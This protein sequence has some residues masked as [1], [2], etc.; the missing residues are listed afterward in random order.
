MMM[1][2]SQII[3]ERYHV[4]PG[5][6]YAD[7]S[8]CGLISRS[9]V[10]KMQTFMQQLYESGS[11]AANTFLSKDWPRIRMKVSNFV[12]A[13]KSEIALIPNF[14]TGL[15]AILP[16][17]KKHQNVLLFEDDYPSLTQPFVLNDF[18]IT[19]ISSTD[20]FHFDLEEIEAAIK[21]KGIKI[22][23][24]SEVQY[25]TGFSIDMEALG[26]ICKKEGVI[27]I[28]DGTQ[29]LGARPY[30]FKKSAADVY[31]SSNYKWM[32]GGYG[33]GLMAIK[34]AF[35]GAHPPKIGGFANFSEINGEWKYHESILNYEPGHM[36]M[37]GWLVVEDAVDFK[38]EIGTESIFR[39]NQRLLTMLID[40]L[41]NTDFLVGDAGI[42]HRC[43]IIC[44][45][46]SQQLIRSFRNKGVI[47]K[48]R[49]GKIRLGLHFH[50]T[51]KDVKNIINAIRSAV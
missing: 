13:D 6:T 1:I 9:G 41:K 3:Q 48:N 18:N 51:E 31:I 12:N 33:T 32:N 30:D 14:S 37:G 36:N 45:K 24:V 19:W 40:G 46:E 27:L 42:E 22:V 49:L 20:G 26:A 34:Q 5:K 43:G 10:E 35:Q 25:L 50:N 29:S 28:A 38:S 21:T 23:A 7:T 47:F 15:N 11:E 17:L 39:H 4:D 16:A 2:D 8:S 44:M